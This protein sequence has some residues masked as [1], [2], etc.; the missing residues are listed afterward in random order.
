MKVMIEVDIPDM[1]SIEI[2]K[3]AVQRAFSPDWIA[4]WWHI[5]DIREQYDGDGEYSDLTDEQARKVL[6]WMKKC[7]D[8]NVGYNWDYVASCTEDILEEIHPSFDPVLKNE[9]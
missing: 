6:A 7:H 8:A 5:E 3:Y 1:A 2:A 9:V 4:D